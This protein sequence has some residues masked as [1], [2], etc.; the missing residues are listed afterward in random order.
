MAGSTKKNGKPK[1]EMPLVM[2]Q[3][4]LC[5]QPFLLAFADYH[6]KDNP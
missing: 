5:F 1:A 2:C 6:S 4:A 3:G